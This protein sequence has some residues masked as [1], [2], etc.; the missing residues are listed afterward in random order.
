MPCDFL[1][2]ET[3]TI[4]KTAPSGMLLACPSPYSMAMSSLGFSGIYQTVNAHPQWFCERVTSD[5]RKNSMESGRNP[6]EFGVI[7]FSVSYELEIP[8]IIR[9][10][11]DWSIPLRKSHRDSTY[12][13][14]IAGGALTTI[15]P[16]LLVEIFDIVFTGD[17]DTNF[18]IFLDSACISDRQELLTALG[19]HDGIY[20]CFSDYL[21]PWKFVYENVRGITTAVHSDLAQFGNRVLTEVNRGCSRA[22]SFCTIGRSG[23]SRRCSFL[24]LEQ[25]K[26][27]IGDA[28]ATGLVGAAVSDHPEILDILEFCRQKNIN[29]SLSSLRGDRLTPEMLKLLADT[30]T[31]ILTTA[32][33]GASQNIR[34]A[35]HKGITA[36]HIISAAQVAKEL[37]IWKLK[38][39]EIIGLAGETEEDIREM[40]DFALTLSRIIPVFMTISVFV[41]KPFTLLADDAFPD[42]GEIKHK[43]RTFQR[44]VKGKI[45]LKT[46]SWNE[47]ACE[48]LIG[49]LSEAALDIIERH[50]LENT[51]VSALRR[52]L[53]SLL[54]D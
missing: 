33:D 52:D 14:L 18:Q 12:P 25:V 26:Q 44:L 22:C 13:L 28:S 21:S 43:I 31:K 30:G 9:M 16:G 47:A 34:N 8:E 3:G 45:T 24:P 41:P 6:R 37:G 4:Y 29:V 40:A 23:S 54:S 1:R 17:A 42:N 39:Y 36:E 32:A 19:K 10:L 5:C 51:S 7:G 20:T 27:N 35:I 49:K 38:I 15:V 50:A 48:Y 11:H 53:F 2:S 46:T